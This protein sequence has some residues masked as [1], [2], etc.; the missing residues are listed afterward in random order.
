[1]KKHFLILSLAAAGTLFAACSE[2]AQVEN[3]ARQEAAA[4]TDFYRAPTFAEP[5]ESKLLTGT[6][7]E[8]LRAIFE[9]TGP[10]IIRTLGTVTI[11]E[12]QYQEIKEFTDNLVENKTGETDKY[13]AIFNWVKSNVKY[14][15]SNEAYSNDA[16]EVF[17][18]KIAV[19]QGYSNLQVVMCHT[20]G[21]P[22]VVV[23]G[24]ASGVGHAW[25]YTCPDNTWMVS[26]PTNSSDW[27][28]RYPVS[29]THLSPKQADAD[30]FEDETAVYNFFDYA[31]NVKEVTTRDNPFAIPYSAGGFVITSFNPSS[32]LPE[33]ITEIYVGQNVTTFG[34]TDNMRLAT[35]NYGENIRAIYVDENNPKLQDHKGIVYK[36][37]GEELQLYYIPGG[38]EYIELIPMEVVDKNTI[39]RHSNVKE[40][41]FPEGVKEILP[42]AV[43]NCPKLER[44]YIPEGVKKSGTSFPKNVEIIYGIPSSIKHITID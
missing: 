31:V 12:E 32:P 10:D 15:H 28:M 24:D 44:V 25:T 7:S 40:I 3:Y 27:Y 9:A 39:Y 23:N 34:E 26:D 6:P 18:N 4:S 21:I 2:Q 17:T 29:Y 22:A 19:C 8:N 30:I 38:M 41:Y 37:N 42:Y 16:Y 43:E 13:K 1:M 36:K 20:Q 11:T 5:D 35:Q 33:E 14:N